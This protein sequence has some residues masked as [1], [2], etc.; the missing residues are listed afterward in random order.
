ML[1]PKRTALRDGHWLVFFL[2]VLSAWGALYAMQLPEA[3]LYGP[4]F[5]IA[6]C[7]ATP[8]LKGYPVAFLMWALMTVA[9]MAPTFVPALAVFD[10]LSRTGAVQR[11]GFPELAGGYLLVW[12]GFAGLAAFAQVLLAEADV[13]SPDGRMQSPW[14]TAMLLVIA[15]AY[16]FSTL[17]QAC[18]SRCQTPFHFFMRHWRD[19][20]W[21]SVYMGLRMGVVCLG[22]CWA[23]MLLAFIGGAMNLLWM[24]AATFLMVLEKLPQISRFTVRPLG[25]ALILAG[26]ACAA[27]VGQ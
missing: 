6:L 15:G 21:N 7:Q 11:S 20:R 5:W 13:L 14:P 18:L 12:L 23:L 9:M 16:Q 19:E 17:K 22:C 4:E 1:A 3:A 26:L 25:A 10:E 2:G 24:G 8:G 27:G